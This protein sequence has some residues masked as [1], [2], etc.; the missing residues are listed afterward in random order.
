MP[1]F[2][3]REFLAMELYSPSTFPKVDSET[4]ST[5]MSKDQKELEWNTIITWISLWSL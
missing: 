5:I 4:K 1:D 3:Y 2:M